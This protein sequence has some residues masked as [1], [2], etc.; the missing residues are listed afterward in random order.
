[1]S[2]LSKGRV[3]RT[4]AL[5]AILVTAAAAI[6]AGC[7]GGSSDSTSA[8]G[9]R[10]VD[11]PE[12]KDVSFEAPKQTVR[13]GEKL[14]AVVST[15]CGSFEIALDTRQA[16]KIVNSFAFLAREGL[17]DG[18]D[19]YKVISG[20]A[21]YAG[22]PSGEGGGP[23]YSIVEKPPADTKYSRGVVAMAREPDRPPGYSGS[24]FFVATSTE[25]GLPPDFA[26]LGKV[27]KGYGTVA[28]I[29]ELGT[30]EQEPEQT[31]LI[32]KLTIEKG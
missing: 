25:T 23:G 29:N 3:R 7:G 21:V 27:S 8:S 10:Q 20:F 17:Y 9:C 2:Y 26:L 24:A 6:T 19:F 15:S 4:L 18:L 13:K 14:T 5:S 32:E 31:V 28:L 12:T 11:A 1:M 16:P 30:A 22:D